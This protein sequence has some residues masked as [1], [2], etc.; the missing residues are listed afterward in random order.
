MQDNIKMDLIPL[1]DRV[2]NQIYDEY[3]RIKRQST[4]VEKA[5]S[6]RKKIFALKN[7][8]A[9]YKRFFYEIYALS[10]FEHL[11]KNLKNGLMHFASETRRIKNE[12]DVDEV[13]FLSTLALRE[14]QINKITFERDDDTF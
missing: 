9:K 11:P 5:R 7:F 14:L 8:R 13:L 2:K 6:N 3:Q 10:L 4:M 12:K 1:Y